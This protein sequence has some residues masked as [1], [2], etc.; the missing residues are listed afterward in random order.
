[1]APVR[2]HDARQEPLSIICIVKVI[3]KARAQARLARPARGVGQRG[4]S[5][6]PINLA[7]RRSLPITGTPL[8]T[9]DSLDILAGGLPG[10]GR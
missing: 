1:M 4:G 5:P 2:Y 9:G 6:L 10:R 3:N 8:V 7:R